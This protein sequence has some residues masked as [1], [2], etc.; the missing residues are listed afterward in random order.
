[1]K[2][3]QDID[4]TNISVKLDNFGR[5]EWQY[6]I[7]NFTVG[8]TAIE[9]LNTMLVALDAN[10][11]TNLLKDLAKLPYNYDTFA[12]DVTDLCVDR[13]R[14]LPMINAAIGD[15]ILP[16]FYN[17]NVAG[18]FIE[19]TF[20]W[21]DL[22]NR[23]IISRRPTTYT[24]NVNEDSDWN[25]FEQYYYQSLREVIYQTQDS[26]VNY[27]LDD[28]GQRLENLGALRYR[29]VKR[30]TW[31]NYKYCGSECVRVIN[32]DYEEDVVFY[33]WYEHHLKGQEPSGLLTNEKGF[34]VYYEV[35]A[36]KDT[37]L[38]ARDSFH[39]D[40]LSI[41]ISRFDM[42]FMSIADI[43]ASTTSAINSTKEKL[44]HFYLNYSK[45]LDKEGDKVFLQ[46]LTKSKL[47]I[48]SEMMQSE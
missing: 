45:R 32:M 43:L 48:L 4:I 33:L 41:A 1:M 8:G 10:K 24:F 14:L 11:D 25:A 3:N 27:Y 13:K 17:V 16:K 30:Q 34:L 47:L 29:N 20:F 38:L 42:L 26:R 40:M 19:F 28:I 7:A 39:V 36:E 35:W 12:K 15:N 44:Y 22:Y 23:P 46:R 21:T 9:S 5:F 18:R 2:L 31:N 6:D 37:C